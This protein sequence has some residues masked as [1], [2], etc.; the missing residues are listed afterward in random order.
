[1]AAEQ[2]VVMVVEDIHTLS[3]SMLDLVERL[4]VHPRDGEPPIA[5]PRAH[6]DR[7]LGRAT[8]LGI[9]RGQR[10]AAADGPALDGRVDR[11]GSAGRRRSDHGR[12]GDPRSRKRTGGNP[13]FIVET[14]GMLL[15]ESDGRPR[16][17]R[18]ALP[19]TV[20]AVVTARLDALPH[21][22]PHARPDARR[23]SGTRSRSTS[24]PISTRMSTIRRAPRAR[25]RGDR[26]ARGRR[27]RLRLAYAALHAARR[28]VREPAQARTHATARD[29]RRSA[30][31]IGS[32]FVRGRTSGAGRAGVPRP[33]PASTGG[34]WIARSTS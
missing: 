33:E 8:V 13:F 1:M 9:E 10:R 22:P 14:T 26:R 17:M 29:H 4:G 19:P 25:G 27:G 31:R 32:P 6:A 12:R 21:A 23:S 15:P 30:H 24:S 11:P 18:G 3:G 5:H 2:P 28:R 20:Q 7:V 34:W 16:R